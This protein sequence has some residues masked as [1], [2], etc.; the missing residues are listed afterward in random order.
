MNMQT[1]Y[2]FKKDVRIVT[3]YYYNIILNGL[4]LNGNKVCE[5]ESH[6]S[7]EVKKLPKDTYFLITSFDTF[8]YLFFKGFRNFIYWYQ[9]IVPEEDFLRTRSKLRRLAFS[10]AEKF[11]LKKVKF[12]ICVSKYQVEFYEKKYHLNLKHA[13]VMP[14]FNSEFNRDNF[15]LSDKYEHNVFC[16]AGGIQ[17]YQ[18]FNLILDTYKEIEEKYPNTFLKIYTFD[19]EKAKKIIKTYDIKNFSVESVPQSEVDDV[20]AKCKFGFLIRDNNMIN[21][22]ATPTKLANYLGNG[23]VPI[24]TDTIKAYADIAKEYEHLYCFGDTDKDI[25]IDK[26]LHDVIAPDDLEKEYRNVMDKFL[27]LTN[28]QNNFQ[29]ISRTCKTRNSFLRENDMMYFKKAFVIF[30]LF[31]LLFMCIGYKEEIDTYAIVM[32]IVIALSSFG[33]ASFMLKNKGKNILLLTFLF[34]LVLSVCLRLVFISYDKVSIFGN[35]PNNDAIN[36]FRY[37]LLENYKTIGEYKYFLENNYWGNIDDFGY[38]FYLFFIHK[39]MSQDIALWLVIIFNAFLIAF[40]AKFLYKTCEL[41]NK[42]RSDDTNSRI[43]ATLF[44]TFTFFVDISATGR[45]EDLFMFFIAGAFYYMVKYQRTRKMTDLFWFGLFGGF[46]IFFRTAVTFIIVVSF[47]LGTYVKERNKKLYTF[48]LLGAAFLGL[49]MINIVAEKVLGK[50]MD[51]I[52]NIAESR[53]NSAGNNSYG[54]KWE[55]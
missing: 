16:Y 11:S 53:Y 43:I 26:A 24:F 55:I 25:V 28:I 22:V 18:G 38:T 33:Y 20:L 19:L 5:I 3:G 34:Q 52:Y 7:P 15:Y 8:V 12:P 39:V 2:Y 45:K 47:I 17:A 14:C 13:F 27:I 35:D 23:V 10:L 36:Y 37:A 9:G 46:T 49:I 51:D 1:I 40:S 41:Y 50:S 31:Y 6:N 42:N 30:L 21:Q 32:Q 48:I 54:K 4:K 44:S 29:N